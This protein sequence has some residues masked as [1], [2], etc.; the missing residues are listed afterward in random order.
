M[1]VPKTAPG[2][3]FPVNSPTSGVVGYGNGGAG[4]GAET[5]SVIIVGSAGVDTAGLS[6]IVVGV[7]SSGAVG[8]L[9]LESMAWV[10][11]FVGSGGGCT[12][13]AA[14]GSATGLDIVKLGSGIGAAES[15]AV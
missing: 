15:V 13:G 1:G 11:T 6:E 5:A 8:V 2:I 10:E 9:T 14:A 12:I 4:T 3:S 7:V